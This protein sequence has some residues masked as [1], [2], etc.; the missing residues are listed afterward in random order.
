MSL[1]DS[2]G[3]PVQPQLDQSQVMQLMTGLRIRID[4]ANAQLV[5]LGLLV[6]YLYENLEKLEIAIPMDE[7]PT[8]AEARYAEIQK[9]AQEAMDQNKSDID[10][11]KRK[12]KEEVDNTASST[13]LD[14][15]KDVE[16]ALS[17][18]TESLTE[19]YNKTT[20]TSTETTDTTTETTD[21]ETTN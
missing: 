8:W 6:E 16:D 20:T 4:A 12:L 1:L 15:G 21:T 11:I 17:T 3:N 5:Q 10:E 19:T 7:F 9:Q 14:F 13:G 18:A 2:A